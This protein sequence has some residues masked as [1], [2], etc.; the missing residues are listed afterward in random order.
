MNSFRFRY[1]LLAAVK[2]VFQSI[3]EHTPNYPRSMSREAISICKGFL[4]KNPKKRLAC[5]N[6]AESDIKSKITA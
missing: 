6:N 3:M 2:L 1:E 4:T 5:G